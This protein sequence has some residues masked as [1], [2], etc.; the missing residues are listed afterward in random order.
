MDFHFFLL[1]FL[2]AFTRVFYFYFCHNSI[3]FMTLVI[4]FFC[5]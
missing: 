3:P 1:S 4:F 2:P 5:G